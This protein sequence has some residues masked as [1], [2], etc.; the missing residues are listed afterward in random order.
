MVPTRLWVAGVVSQTRDRKLADQLLQQVRRCSKT[1]CDLLICTDGWSPYPNSIKRAFREK[2]KRAGKR[3]RC[4]LEVW[5]ELHIGTVIK[6]TVNKHLKEV[7][8]QVS[9]GNLEKAMKLLEIS[10]GGFMLNTSHIERF[11]GT[12]RERLA[13]MTRKC[14]HA[15]EKLLAF[16]TG[17][18]LIGCTYN[19]CWFH[20]ELSK[21][22]EKGGL[23]MPCTPAMT[24]GLTDHQWSLFDLLSYKVAPPPLP[25][26]KRRGRPRIKPSLDPNK[27]KPKSQKARVR[28][29]KGALCSTTG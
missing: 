23:G 10:N 4:A 11:N 2:I 15:S 25:I 26:P 9:Y 1:L 28:L 24:S 17:M 27:L 6:H 20:Q 14:R 7:I 5:P 12:I 3:G 29:R 16:H 19:F 13:S 18:Y 22:I 21:N 8:R